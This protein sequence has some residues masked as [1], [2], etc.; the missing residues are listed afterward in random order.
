MKR[1]ARRLP[2]RYRD[3]LPEATP[4]V[5]TSSVT[6][7]LPVPT[8]DQQ[9]DGSAAPTV[10]PGVGSLRERIQLFFSTHRNQFALFRRYFQEGPPSHDPE[11][12]VTLENLCDAESSAD[13]PPPGGVPS[14]AYAPYPNHNAFLLGD[15]YWNG[16]PQKISCSKDQHQPT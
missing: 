2:L 1:V 8:S 12:N 4:A 14:N 13:S 11:E 6:P 9:C 3:I 16:G 5:G 10:V 15:W 7:G